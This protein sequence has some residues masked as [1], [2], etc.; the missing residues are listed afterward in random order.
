MPQNAAEN[1]YTPSASDLSAYV[2]KASGG[3]GGAPGSYLTRADGQ[4]SGTTDAILKWASC[5]WGFDENVT[6]AT[7]VNE[8][9]WRQTEL[10]DIGNG[11]S[12][13]IL[14]IKSRDYPSSCEAVASSQNTSLVTDTDL[15]FVPQYGLCR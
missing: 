5:K 3:E 12:I 11:T 9:H 4:F 10:G 15:L 7:A 8:T 2:S 14:Q 6:R 1:T 13:G